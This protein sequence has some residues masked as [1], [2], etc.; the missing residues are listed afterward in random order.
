M[1]P[2][3][4]PI[5]IIIIVVYM[6]FSIGVGFLFSKKASANTDEYFVGGR[7][8]PWWLI[9][10]S[11]VATTFAS[12]TPLAMTEM[13]REHGMCAT[14]FGGMPVSPKLWQCFCSPGC[15][16]GPGSLP[17][18]SFWKFATTA[19]ALRC[20]VVSKRLISR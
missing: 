10:T 9:G 3:L 5:D 17:T 16:V 1:E 15:G 2:S 14:G 8:M 19:K 11:M 20:C 6:A 12:D 4:A 18:T 13:I 7:S